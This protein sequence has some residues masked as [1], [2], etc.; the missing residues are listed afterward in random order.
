[1]LPVK[2][3]VCCFFSV[4][5]F[6]IYF[7]NGSHLGFTI[8]KF[9]VFLIYRSLRHILPNFESADPFVQEKPKFV[10]KDGGMASISDFRLERF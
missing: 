4:Q 7:R 8:G 1:M 3:Q 5:E 2:F 6:K 10:F 9:K